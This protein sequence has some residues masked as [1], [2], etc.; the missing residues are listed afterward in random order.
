MNRNSKKT[1]HGVPPKNHSRTGLIISLIAIGILLVFSVGAL[2]VFTNYVS[3]LNRVDVGNQTVTITPSPIPG[4]ELTEN[5]R[6]VLEDADAQLRDNLEA[7]AD[8]NFDSKDVTNILLIG[9]DNDYLGG[10]D[11]LGNADGILLVS[12]NSKTEQ[13]VLTSFMRDSYV[14]AAGEDYNTKLTLTYHYGG[15]PLLINTMEANFGIPIDSY[16]LV[17]Y[18][19]VV[20]IVDAFGGID[21]EMNQSELYYTQQKIENVNYLTAQEAGANSLEGVLPGVVHLNG[22]QVAALLRIR[23][24][25]GNDQGRTQRARQVILKLKEKAT[26]MSFRELN[27]MANI[28]LPCVTTNLTQGEIFSL[29]LNSLSYFK[30]DM[31]SSRVPYEGSYHYENIYGSSM[32][33]MDYTANKE[34]LYQ[35]IYEGILEP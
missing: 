28:V 26:N 15:T 9:V 21:M 3:K 29:M 16:V 6:T 30:Y 33:V 23:L 1:R 13:V 14:A 18:I 11:Q 32:V 25:G 31:I 35:S 20:D 5:E 4:A 34:Y 24:D 8:K 19:N 22:T 7:K 12:I 10:M 17:N 27:D 2:V